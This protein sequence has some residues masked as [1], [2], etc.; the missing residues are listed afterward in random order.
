MVSYFEEP[1]EEVS[2]FPCGICSKRIHKNHKYIICNL[3][4]YRVH[5]KCNKE[6][7]KNK[8]WEHK[9]C[10]KCKEEA[11]PFQK[12][13]DHQ[14]FATSKGG[15]NKDID[16]LDLTIFPINRLKSF[17]KDI[18]DLNTNLKDDEDNLEEINCN[19]LDID[20][21]HYKN[22]KDN[23]SLFHL[24]IASLCKHKEELETTLNLIN[25]KFDV[26][27]ITETKIRENR[28]P[29]IDINMTGYKT[30]STRTEA[31]KGGALLY[32]GEHLNSKPY[33]ILD[34]I[35]YK[36]KQLESVFIEI[37][38]KGKKNI[39]IGCIYRHPSMELDEF[40]DDFLEPLLE[41]LST[42]DKTVFLMGDFNVDL[43]KIESDPHTSDFF[44]SMTSNLFVPHIVYP[45]RITSTSK[46]LIDNIYS[47]SPYF[48][49][50][51]SGN[52]TLTISDHMAQFLI[53]PEN[54]DNN[55]KKANIYKR[56]HKN[57]DRVNFT[58]DLLEIDWNKVIDIGRNDPNEC[59]NRFEATLNPVIDKYLPL[60]K[61]S[62]KD[63][64]NHFKPWITIGIRNSIKRREK[65][66]KKFIKA[67]NEE[68]KNVYHKQYKD[69]RNDI[70]KLCRQSKKNHYQMFFTE[71]ANNLKSTWKGIK[72]IIN[73]KDRDNNQLN[74]IMIDDT[75]CT[76]S[77]KIA[78]GFN[79]YFATIAEKLQSR[80]YHEGHDF[81]K[82]LTEKNEKSFF[83]E[84]TD[85][86]EIK[87]II[88]NFS[89][90]KASGPHSIPNEILQYSIDI[91][92]YPLNRLINHSFTNGIYFQN[93]K[94]SK[95]LPIY[96]NKGNFLE[97]ENYRPIS[98]LSNVNKIIE[99]LMHERLNKF[100]SVNNCIF[101][102][103]FGFRSK[104]ST[105]HALISLTEGIRSS[106][107]KNEIA[108][109]IF[110]DLQKAFDTVDHN[111][112]LSKLEHYGIRGIAH[113][114]F[115]SYLSN[116][117]QFV[118][119]NGEDSTE[120][121]ML[122]GV[123]QGSVLGPLLFL[124]YINDLHNSIKHCITRHFADDTC[125]LIS[126]T[127]PKK[128]QKQLNADLRSLCKWLK[129]NKISLN[130][131]KTELLLFR[132]PNKK[133]NYEFKIKIDG[134]KIIPSKYVKYLGVLI[135]QHLNWNFHINLLNSKLSRVVGMLAKIRYYVSKATLRSIY[136]A[137]FASQLT[138]GSQIFGQINNKQFL[139]LECLQNKAIR[140]IN[141]AKYRATV[142]PLYK[143]SKILKIADNIKLQ[144]F[145]LVFSDAKGDLPTALS[146]TFKLAQESH[147][148]NTRGASQHK[149]VL[150]AAKTVVYGLRS[151]KYQSITI[152]NYLM[153]KYKINKLYEK[154]KL[155]CK[156]FITKGFLDS[157]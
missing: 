27:G 89:A 94:I 106:L 109:G 146:N 64:K 136:Y 140:I 52:L 101:I 3:C 98:L 126:N 74:S 28:D 114:W 119:I 150:P 87:Q 139:R 103:Q 108:C 18:N 155:I 76:D 20:E 117:K 44:D 8:V 129:A 147:R 90:N 127:S 26:L 135:D 133:I 111:I 110:I 131:S 154:S 14:F 31:A 70:V 34:K 51:I 96:K 42:K 17:F 19:Y 33:K 79:E 46:T 83:I 9:L 92:V 156:K 77:R 40:N 78:N 30:Y 12:L 43:M 100:L 49:Q 118:N 116:R 54:N 144:N 130:A 5:F 35:M 37:C 86:I 138:Y 1:L 13:T 63:V 141:F 149:M 68:S 142:N 99:K 56:D 2:S 157:Y 55:F 143:E 24:N 123:P 107:D 145:L 73:I 45:T 10:I 151:I 122:Y 50:G 41:E 134:K 112:L 47:N 152:W 6:D 15:I 102:N 113:D 61:L 84:P 39:I 4:N 105:N 72:Q 85:E 62:R 7:N 65:L 21:F 97:V 29:L 53:I 58:L 128:L 81:T 153:G 69:L 137:I 48:S 32:V 115:K 104:H 25:L 121:E 36:P 148:Y 82:Y 80:I 91:L 66:Y 93:L 75:L 67:K 22:K 88:K 120:L 124:L 125:L 38:N 95:T 60:K 23:L 16:S 71:N 11:I 132:H 57:F 59:F